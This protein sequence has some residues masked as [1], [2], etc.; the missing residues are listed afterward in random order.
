MIVPARMPSA[1]PRVVA[2]LDRLKDAATRTLAER[3]VLLA[4][5]RWAN[6]RGE[7]WVAS[8]KWAR[9]AGVHPRTLREVLRNLE[10]RGIV[11]RTVAS[12]GGAK[13][14]SRYVVPILANPAPTPGLEREGTR[15]VGPQ[16]P[17]LHDRKPGSHARGSCMNVQGTI[18]GGPFIP[19]DPT[20]DDLAA[21]FGRDPR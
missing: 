7:I 10:D 20:D 11:V 12:K 15:A 1:L 2:A 5:A 8:E 17:G 3:A 14:T 13:R 6:E 4:S 19:R 18:T 16:N 21:V 9:L